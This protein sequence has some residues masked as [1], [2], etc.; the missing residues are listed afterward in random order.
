M[1]APTA[2]ETLAAW[3]CELRYSEID[4]ATVAYAKELLL[5]H[6]GCAVRGGTIDTAEAVER[7][8]ATVGAG[9]GP[10]LTAVIG[11]RP[12]RPEWAVFA[13]GV[14]AHS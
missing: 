5:D 14:Y 6:L 10:A 7:M 1:R 12:L 9:E 8:L 3:V 13:H 11:K 4:A 2:S